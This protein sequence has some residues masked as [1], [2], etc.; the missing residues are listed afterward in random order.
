MVAGC[1]AGMRPARTLRRLVGFIRKKAKGLGFCPAQDNDSIPTPLS[2][3][4]SSESLRCEART[5]WQQ[6]FTSFEREAYYS[7]RPL[8]STSLM[9]QFVT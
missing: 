7:P 8:R 6:A 2:N 5:R 3:P 1:C 9:R 4:S